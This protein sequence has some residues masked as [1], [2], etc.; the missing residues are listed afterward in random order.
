VTGTSEVSIAS[1]RFWNEFKAYV[2]GT[3]SDAQKHQIER[4]LSTSSTPINEQLSD[5]RLSFK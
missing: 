5:L 3:L 4:V 2:A 1:D